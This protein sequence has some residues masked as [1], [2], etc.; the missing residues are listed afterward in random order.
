MCLSGL[1]SCLGLEFS[2]QLESWSCWDWQ[3]VPGVTW[4]AVAMNWSLQWLARW[5]DPKKI[6]CEWFVLPDEAPCGCDST[7]RNERVLSTFL[8]KFGLQ[9][10]LLQ[11][12]PFGMRQQNPPWDHG[13]CSPPQVEWESRWDSEMECQRC[14]SYPEPLDSYGLLERHFGLNVF[15]LSKMRVMKQLMGAG[16]ACTHFCLCFI[17]HHFLIGVTG[18]GHSD[19]DYVGE[20]W[21]MK[22][23]QSCPLR[24]LGFV[25]TGHIHLSQVAVFFLSALSAMSHIYS[26]TGR[27][28]VVLAEQ[29]A[30]V[31]RAQLR[32]HLNLDLQC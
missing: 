11:Q 10:K 17:I 23:L 25:C 6:V 13:T 15:S 16:R 2:G 18:P 19:L 20:K 31:W 12:S 1:L 5:N 3:D 21:C 24:F 29:G 26:S 28:A 9:Q 8:L 14:P 4:R 27:V 32:R 30:C 7:G 22:P